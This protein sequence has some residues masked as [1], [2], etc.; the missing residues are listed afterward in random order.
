[1]GKIRLFSLHKLRMTLQRVWGFINSGETGVETIEY[2]W[3]CAE[4]LCALVEIQEKC[5]T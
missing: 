2:Q 1:M 4:L 5:Q 3:E